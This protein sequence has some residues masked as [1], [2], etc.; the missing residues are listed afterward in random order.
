LLV[1]GY[2][3]AHYGY[4]RSTGDMDIWIAVNPANAEALVR[5]LREFG[6]SAASALPELFLS[7]NRVFRMGL[8]PLRIDLITSASGVEFPDCYAR[9]RIDVI[10]GVEVSVISVEDLKTNKRASNR[11]KDLDD[12][13]HL[14]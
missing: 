4:P 3:V 12:L 10:D 13:K 6:F 5:A 14:P 2:A 9:R 7:E 1:G 8:P 11:L